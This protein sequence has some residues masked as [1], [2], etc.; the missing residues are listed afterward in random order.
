MV[1]KAYNC[2]DDNMRMHA[3]FDELNIPHLTLST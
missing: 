3:S 2:T 1:D